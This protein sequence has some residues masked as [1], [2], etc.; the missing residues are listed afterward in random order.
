VESAASFAATLSNRH[1]LENTA[2]PFGAEPW[3]SIAT[4]IFGFSTSDFPSAA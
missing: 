3:R 4:A 2:A 1:Q